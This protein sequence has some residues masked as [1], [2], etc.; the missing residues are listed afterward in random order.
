MFVRGLRKFS[1]WSVR[2]MN[3]A[4]EPVRSFLDLVSSFLRSQVS[5]DSWKGDLSNMDDDTNQDFTQETRPSRSQGRPLLL[6]DSDEEF[7]TQAAR[8]QGPKAATTKKAAANRGKKAPVKSQP[9]FLDDNE[10][11]E[12]VKA[13]PF[14]DFS[15]IE[16]VAQT[17]PSTL[18]DKRPA[19]RTAASKSKKASA[20]IVDDDSD[21]DAFKGFKG[22]KRH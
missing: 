18:P 2:A 15:D 8:K 7:P 6:D 17:L 14:D 19:R 10:D 9:L 16:E 21:E 4:W 22:R 5:P 11:D 3:T 12:D 20:I 1:L 13:E